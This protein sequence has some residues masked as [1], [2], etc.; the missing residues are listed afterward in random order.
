MKIRKSFLSVAKSVF[1]SISDGICCLAHDG[2]G[3]V[4]DLGDSLDHI[5]SSILDSADC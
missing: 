4:F 5:A 2:A 3:F 1:G